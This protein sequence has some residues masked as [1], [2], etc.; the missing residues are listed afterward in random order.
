MPGIAGIISQMPP[1]MN[2]KGLRLMIG[3][4]MHESFYTSGTY[5]NEELGLYA[6]W[7]CHKGSFSDCMPVFNEEKT[8]LLL[9][10]GENFADK[11]ATDQ[12]KSRGH[13]FDDS[14]ASYL[15]H[16]Y[17]EQ[18]NAFLERLNGWFNGVL[19]DLRKGRAVLFNDRYG[20]QRIYYHESK[21]GFYFSSEAKS[22]LK[23]LPALRRIDPVSLGQFFACGCVLQNRTLFSEIH[24]LPGGSAWTFS[25]GKSVKRDFYFKP[26]AWEN[27]PVLEKEVFYD[28]FK[29]TFLNILPRYFYSKQPIA[30]SLTGGLDTRMI[31][32]CGDNPPGS[33][34]CY[35]FGGM[36]GDIRDVR[37][38]RQVAEACHQTHYVLRLD[39]TF[40]S[41]FAKYAEKTIH[42][43]DGCFNICGTHEVYLNQLAREIAPIRMTGN[44]GGEVLR[45]VSTFK[46][47]S[48]C[49]SL[50]HVD[51]KEYLDEARKTFA[52]IKGGHKLSFIVFKEVPWWLFGYRTAAQSQLTQRTP[53]LDKDIVELVYQSPM[54]A[55]STD[56]IALR[57]IEDCNPALFNIMTDLGFGGGS[58]VLFSK[59]AQ[60]LHWFTFKLEWYYNFGMPHWLAKLDHRF[61]TLHLERLFLGHHKIDHYRTWFRSKLS[62]YVREILLDR[63]AADRPYLNKEFL[64]EMVEGHMN[65]FQNYTSEINR[66]ITAELIHRLLIE[67]PQNA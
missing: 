52:E 42:V 67:N 54:D 58:N 35:T 3:C 49:E 64:K 48:P 23:V 22:L 61:R 12:L 66:T 60:L 40:F 4:M 57:L 27:Q 8:L 5:L 30:M 14:N 59:S 62:D 11:E 38:A 44:Y 21:D 55:R 31:L 45:S 37:V 7:V 34:P 10:T 24:S 50:F 19:V 25:N 53:F 56:E 17:E 46:T 36:D 26:S 28:R 2:E 16:V 20:M 13:R 32:A 33:L 15:I 18:G 47:I 41:D 1:E 43:T 39:Q 29:E 9:F 65:G 51:F 63:R 6:G